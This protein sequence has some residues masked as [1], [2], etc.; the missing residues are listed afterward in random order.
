MVRILKFFLNHR[1]KNTSC[2]SLT[3][4]YC[5]G[6]HER[7]FL[8]TDVDWSSGIW[9]TGFHAFLFQDMGRRQGAHLWWLLWAWGVAGCHV[10]PADLHRGCV[11]PRADTPSETQPSCDLAFCAGSGHAGERL[12]LWFSHLGC[13]HR[14]S[15]TTALNSL[16]L[17]PEKF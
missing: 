11:A 9:I 15:N 10:F 12:P 14:R 4:S 7:A 1:G 5:K 13:G 8:N 16:D 3:W 2:V 6:Y 17:Q